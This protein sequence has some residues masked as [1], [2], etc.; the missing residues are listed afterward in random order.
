ML[1]VRSIRTRFEEALGGSRLKMAILR[2]GYKRAA[3]AYPFEPVWNRTFFAAAKQV[4]SIPVF[5]VGGIRSRAECDDIL[6]DGTAD[7]VGIGRPF[8]AE[9]HL[10]QRILGPAVHGDDVHALCESSNRCVPAQQLGMKARCYNPRVAVMK[11]Q[12][13]HRP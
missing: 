4:V 13:E 3:T 6:S 1:D 11:K 9:P 12:L 7:M 2:W 8:Y 5:A 10:A